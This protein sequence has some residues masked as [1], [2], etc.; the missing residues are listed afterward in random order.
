MLSLSVACATLMNGPPVCRPIGQCLL[1][2]PPL[3]AHAIVQGKLL[4][5]G[6]QDDGVAK[7]VSSLQQSPIC[8][9]W[10]VK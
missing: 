2:E 5:I 9:C 8:R 4:E 7:V 6:V 3:L 10:T 1:A